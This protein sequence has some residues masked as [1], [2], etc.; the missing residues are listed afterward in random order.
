VAWIVP[1]IQITSATVLVDGIMPQHM[2]EGIRILAS[3]IFYQVPSWEKNAKNYR[4]VFDTSINKLLPNINKQRRMLQS[5]NVSNENLI[6][7][8]WRFKRTGLT[9]FFIVD[10]YMQLILIACA[11]IMLIVAVKLVFKK[12]KTHKHLSKIYSIFHKVHEISLMYLTIG[13][14]LEWVYFNSQ[15]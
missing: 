6:P 11:W 7:A 1:G 4:A 13:M 14:M 8:G 2:Y 10:I 3:F 12:N 9:T 15:K 5:L